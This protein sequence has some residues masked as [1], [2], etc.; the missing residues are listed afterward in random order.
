M[1]VMPE[2]GLE[3]TM[4]MALAATVVKRNEMTNTSNSEMAVKSQLWS[5]PNWKK[6]NT[7]TSTAIST[8]RMVFMGRSRSVRSQVSAFF[9]PP[10][11][12][13]ASPSA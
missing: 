8:E 4:A 1:S 12:L 13:T 11:S 7:A 10:S 6:K 3:P 5:T 9:L 2:T